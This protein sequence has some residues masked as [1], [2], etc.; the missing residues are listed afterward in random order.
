MAEPDFRRR[1]LSPPPLLGPPQGFR[2]LV[3]ASH[4]LRCPLWAVLGWRSFARRASPWS[5]PAPSGQDPSPSHPW[6]LP[7]EAAR[8]QIMTWLNGGTPGSGSTELGSCV[9]RSQRGS[10]IISGDGGVGGRG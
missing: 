4:A 9:P 1:P 10:V 7:A 3:P 6:L 5:V 8:R 2:Q